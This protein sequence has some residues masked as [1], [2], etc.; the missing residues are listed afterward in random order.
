VAGALHHLGVF[1]G[2]RLVGTHPSN[3]YGHWEDCDFLELNAALLDRRMTRQE[4]EEKIPRLIAS[5]RKLG[6]PWGWKDPRT[7]HLLAQYLEFLDAPKFIRCVRCPEEIEASMAR[8][9]GHCGWTLQ[10]A[11][12]VRECREAELDDYLPWYQTLSIDFNDLRLHRETTVR[13]I[14]QFCELAL[15]TK[16]QF[17]A[18]VNFIRPAAAQGDHARLSADLSNPSPLHAR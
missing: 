3:P 7:C 14:I 16:A 12:A 10:A 2:S 8:A 1:M 17:R 9:Y 18:T 13:R 4:W 15:V 6:I 5:R 11:R